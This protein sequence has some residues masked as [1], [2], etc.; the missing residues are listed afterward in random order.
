MRGAVAL[1]VLVALLAGCSHRLVQP[2]GAKHKAGY[3]RREIDTPRPG[4][5]SG[6]DG[7]W[8][9]L[10]SGDARPAEQPPVRTRTRT[11]LLCDRGEECDPPISE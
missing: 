5:L 8:T 7:S 10:R 2:A 6:A 11:T 4:L 3:N 1:A 9:V